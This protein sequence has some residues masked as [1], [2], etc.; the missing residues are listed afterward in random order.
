MRDVR[1]QHAMFSP[2]AQVV[3]LNREI[4]REIKPG[5]RVP[6]GSRY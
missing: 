3:E 2:L 4:S 5:T 6:A 1:E